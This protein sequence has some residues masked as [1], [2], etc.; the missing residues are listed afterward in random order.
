MIIDQSSSNKDRLGYYRV[1][2]FRSYS[3]LEILEMSDQLKRLPT[4]NFNE[5]IFSLYDWK[6]EPSKS[7]RELYADRARQLRK[8]YD[9]IVIFYSGGIDSQNILDTFVENSIPFEE[10]AT[11]NYH[12]L[13]PREDSFL[14][15]EQTYV[16]YPKIKQL[17]QRGIKFL[18][19]PIDLSEISRDILLDSKWDQLRGYFGNTRYATSQLA[20]TYIRERTP[21]Y[22]KI[23]ESGKKL[24]FVWG[25]DKPYLVRTK[26]G[27]MSI[28]FNDQIDVG[29]GTRTQI[30]D[31]EWEYDELF[32]WSADCLDLM[33]KQAH[34]VKSFIKRNLPEDFNPVL[35]SRETAIQERNLLDMLAANH[36]TSNLTYRNL[37]NWLIY[38][39]FDFA[40]YSIGKPSLIVCALYSPREEYWLKDTVFRA[41]TEKTF[42][43]FKSIGKHWWR[44]K[45]HPESGFIKFAKTY[46]LE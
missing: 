31:R 9:H 26:D 46:P 11:Y 42:G 7:L 18:H 13:D 3:K 6:K 12:A 4:W 32:Y 1:G 24:V 15:G 14:H 29:P 30:V 44:E 5:E 19:R 41:Q 27:K 23:I 21:D 40:M 25:V 33:C 36:I 17:Q 20:K 2:D 8:T 43:H 39:N 28:E 37:S 10:I 22:M 34:T 35:F 38:P 16:S 45:D